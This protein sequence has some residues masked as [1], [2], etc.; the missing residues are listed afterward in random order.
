M[1]DQLPVVAKVQ[2]RTGAQVA[3]LVPQTLDEAYRLAD[4]M[5]RSG[6]T[7]NGI[8]T[9]EAVMVAIMAGAELGLPP[10]QACQ[11]FAIINGRPSIWGDAIPALLW[12]NGFKIKE[13][14]E[15]EAADYPD[16]MVAKCEITRPDG[17][18]IERSYSVA[19]AKEGRLWTKDGPWQTSRKRMLQMRARAFAARDGAADL[20]RGLFIAEEAQD[21]T[22]IPDAQTG[23]GM[24]E[25]LTARAT[26]VDAQGFNVRHIGE[27]T[28]HSMDDVLDGDQI[29]A[30]GGAKPKRKR[31]TKAEM[32]A[33]RAAGEPEGNDDASEDE[34]AAHDAATDGEEQNTPEASNRDLSA[35]DKSSQSGA[36]QGNQTQ[37][38]SEAGEPAG[39]E[40]THA[41]AEA[42]DAGMQASP[43]ED[44]RPQPDAPTAEPDKTTPASATPAS[45]ASAAATSSPAQPAAPSGGGGTAEF[46]AVATAPHA[47][48][49]Q[50]YHLASDPVHENGT[51][52]VYKDG[53]MQGHALARD[54]WSVFAEHAPEVAKAGAVEE[55]SPDTSADSPGRDD[56]APSIDVAEYRAKIARADSYQAVR[57]ALGSLRRTAA[58]RD[59]EEEGQKMFQMEAFERLDE[60]RDSGVPGVPLP[61]EEPWVWALHAAIGPAGEVVEAYD[62]LIK[63]QAYA[64]L[65]DAQKQGLADTVAQRTGSLD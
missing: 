28:G 9:P 34:T 60:L 7:P 29:P 8:K 63:T 11:S 56:Y 10:F 24:V 35:E 15:N 48:T 16:E 39:L 21:F 36:P 14:K 44:G 40:A 42:G 52:P 43:A 46:R 13:W 19:D 54:R 20:L 41:E 6:L 12:S 33:A 30:E 59:C 4:A 31:R 51:R 5:S 3:A 61:T 58:F 25:R 37:P 53:V 23:T 22:P 2:L 27:Q 47:K 57:L 45:G 49:G 18:I 50:T 55:K 17:E 38:A 1:T 62:E 26:D 64:I 65:N 32:E